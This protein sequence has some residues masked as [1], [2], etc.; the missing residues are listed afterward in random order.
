MPA[1]VAVEEAAASTSTGTTP[2]AVGG[3]QL[4]SFGSI[5]CPPSAEQIREP[6]EEGS[7]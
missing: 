1:G 7:D 2:P 3:T 4:V 5:I 6:P